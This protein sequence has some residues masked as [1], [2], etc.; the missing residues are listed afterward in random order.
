MFFSAGK[1]RVPIMAD[2]IVGALL[3]LRRPLNYLK[4]KCFVAAVPSSGSK[5]QIDLAHLGP[6]VPFIWRTKFLSNIGTMLS[7]PMPI[8]PLSPPIGISPPMLVFKMSKLSLLR[9]LR[10][11][12][13][14]VALLEKSRQEYRLHGYMGDFE[15]SFSSS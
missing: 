4:K 8:E 13:F 2:A 10:G 3:Y 12:Y 1:V 5:L 6:L 11:G 15:P 14:I 7:A 9:L